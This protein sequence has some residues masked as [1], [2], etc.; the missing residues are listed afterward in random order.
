MQLK[1]SDIRNRQ[2]PTPYPQQVSASTYTMSQDSYENIFVYK[3]WG[4]VSQSKRYLGKDKKTGKYK[5]DHKGLMKYT[6]QFFNENSFFENAELELIN[7][8]RNFGSFSSRD[9]D[10]Y[11]KKRAKAIFQFKR[12]LK[13]IETQLDNKGWT[14]IFEIKWNSRRGEFKSRIRVHGIHFF[15]NT[16]FISEGLEDACEAWMYRGDDDCY[17]CEKE[18]REEATFNKQ[19]A[20]NPGQNWIVLNLMPPIG[21]KKWTKEALDEQLE[22]FSE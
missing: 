3:E 16:P 18:A 2:T 9:E 11:K 13:F 1:F 21:H 10:E 5:Y 8:S 6:T 4:V 12:I 7:I 19:L 14:N 15:N 22:E 17:W 20:H